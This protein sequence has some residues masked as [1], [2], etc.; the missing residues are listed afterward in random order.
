MI[1]LNKQKN[2][3]LG[4]EN[5]SAYKGGYWAGHELSFREPVLRFLPIY[6]LLSLL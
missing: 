3:S 5:H 6:C 1:S 4:L 2:L